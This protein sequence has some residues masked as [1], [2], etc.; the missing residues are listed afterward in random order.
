MK[1]TNEDLRKN[2]FHET[3]Y[4]NSIMYKKVFDKLS[5]VREMSVE[6][7]ENEMQDTREKYGQ[8]IYKKSSLHAFRG[9]LVDWLIYSGKVEHYN[10]KYV[11]S[12]W[13]KI[14]LDSFL[15]KES[16]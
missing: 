4:E 8:K 13:K 14:D 1:E 2:I 3:A 16:K 6:D 10:N 9:V 5:E 12:K 15:N 11:L 7:I